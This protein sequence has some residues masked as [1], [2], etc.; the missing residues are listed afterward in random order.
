MRL[1]ALKLGLKSREERERAIIQALG[2]TDG[3]LVRLALHATQQGVPAGAVPSVIALV[4][5]RQVPRDVRL[6]RSAHLASPT[7]RARST[8]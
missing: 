4:N 7:P 3:R 2:D 1:E 8:C 5:N 6:R